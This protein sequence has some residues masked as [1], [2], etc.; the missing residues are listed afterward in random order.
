MTDSI[1]VQLSPDGN[2][3]PALGRLPHQAPERMWGGSGSGAAC[4]VCGEQISPD[5]ME[6]ELEYRR[7]GNYGRAS[8]HVHVRCC[9]AWGLE[10][11][12]LRLRESTG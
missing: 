4:A 7:A 12:A 8:F 10:R 11:T 1:E 5:Q 6:Y 2:C 3:E 9:P